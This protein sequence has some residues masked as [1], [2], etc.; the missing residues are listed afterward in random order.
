MV[1]SEMVKTTTIRIHRV[2][3]AM[4]RWKNCA[5]GQGGPLGLVESI[6]VISNA[7]TPIAECQDSSLHE[8]SLHIFDS[9]PIDILSSH[10]CYKLKLG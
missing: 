8:S 4:N 10:L 9:D 1:L 5:S 7:P 6:L 2:H 3:R